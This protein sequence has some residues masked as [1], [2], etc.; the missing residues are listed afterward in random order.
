MG[1]GAGICSGL[2]VDRVATL[3]LHSMAVYM[4]HPISHTYR[5]PGELAVLVPVSLHSGGTLG[6]SGVAFCHHFSVGDCESDC[7]GSQN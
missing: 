4:P 5:L 6:Q 3:T 7:T 1:L 2:S